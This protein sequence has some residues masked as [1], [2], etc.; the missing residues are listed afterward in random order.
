MKSRF[1][2]AIIVRQYLLGKLDQPELADNLEEE[3]LFND[4]LSEIVDSIED[5]I[6]EDYLDNKL[7]A[8]DRESFREHFLK[9]QE[10]KDKLRLAFLL[11]RHFNPQEDESALVD[12]RSAFSE[13]RDNNG[14]LR[15][16]GTLV[17]HWRIH[18]RTYLEILAVFV[19]MISGVIYTGRLQTRLLLSHAS[20]RRLENDLRQ[21]QRQSAVL[22]SQLQSTPRIPVLALEP[23]IRL[24]TLPTTRQQQKVELTPNDEKI[25]VTLSLEGTPF[26]LY[27]VRLQTVEGLQ[28]W[29]AK[30]RPLIFSSNRAELAFDMPSQGIITADYNFIVSPESQHA[31]HPDRYPF[32]VMVAIKP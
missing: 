3:M 5:E 31:G 10:R 14:I 28:I 17:D 32:R 11:R 13:S 8:S 6:I 20:E 4:E 1:P 12:L 22:K 7:G 23:E 27:D 16:T 18:S 15:G 2:E 30:V 21:E 25:S 24:R 9:P 26:A 19:L 29:A